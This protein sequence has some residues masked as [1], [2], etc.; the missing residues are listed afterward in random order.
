MLAL[1][2]ACHAPPPVPQLSLARETQS[3]GS[4]ALL[5]AVSAVS[6]DVV[7]VSGQRGTWA[8]SLDG[9]RSWTTG[10]VP[11]GDTLQFRDVYA[12]S[13]D[14]AWLLSAGN[15]DLSRIYRTTDGGRSWTLQ[16]RNTDPAAFYDC[17]DFWDARRGLVFGDEVNGRVMVLET[18]D[19]E[20]WSLIPAGRLPKA[21]DGEGGFAASGTCLITRPGGHAWIGTGNGAVSRVLRTRDYG[22]SWTV[23][24]APIAAGTGAGIATVAF[25]D[26]RRGAVLG[27]PIGE[28]LARTDNVALTMDG[29]VRW[30]TGGRP[31]FAGPVFGAA[32]VPKSG[33]TLVA[34]GPRGASVSWDGGRHWAAVDSLNYWGLGFS[35]DGAGWLVGPRG[36]ITHLLVSR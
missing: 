30:D 25:R 8:R 23:D 15:G 21:L 7:W 28:P 4:T 34:V 19:G 3:S 9:G 12:A 14:T 27:G 32:F 10:G 17:M 35:P 2:G 33:N 24:S 1:L 6:N 13:A 20:H 31:T 18:T 26:D 22:R 29:G 11:E 16:F 5:Q 36:R